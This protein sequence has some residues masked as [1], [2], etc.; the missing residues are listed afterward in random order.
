MRVIKLFLLLLA[1][2]QSLW[3]WMHQSRS[4]LVSLKYSTPNINL[5]QV[6]AVA[7]SYLM[8][9]VGT[10][11]NQISVAAESKISTLIFKTG[12]NPIPPNPPDSKTGTKKDTSF[13][14][15][16]SNCKARCQA[17]GEGLA[18]MD[19]FEDCQ[20]QSCETY[21]QCTFKVKSSMGNSI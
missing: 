2:S 4:K 3:G 17:P 13:L 15:A 7:I 8:I 16:M 20:N 5:K 9:N 6:S 21:E 19:C 10:W 14:R 18:R 1:Y 12:K 11:E